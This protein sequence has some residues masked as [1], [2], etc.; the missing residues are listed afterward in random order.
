[1]VIN[2]E[3]AATRQ[4]ERFLQR[5]KGPWELERI[6]EATQAPNMGEKCHTVARMGRELPPQWLG[7]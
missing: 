2:E 6:G 7:R 4:E 3:Y 5:H 1:M